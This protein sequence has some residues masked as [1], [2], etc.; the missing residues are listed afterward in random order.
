MEENKKEI[1]PLRM[2]QLT[3]IAARVI[4]VMATNAWHLT[5]EEME[6][7]LDLVRYG[8]DETRKR[9]EI[10]IRGEE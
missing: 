6:I 9:N 2:G 3:D 1:T 10:S 7:I 8:M 4:K 5:F